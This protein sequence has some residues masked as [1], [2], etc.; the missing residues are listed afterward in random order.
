M[1]VA[2]IISNISG[3]DINQNRQT[4]SIEGDDMTKIT[5]Q[6]ISTKGVD[7]KDVGGM[8]DECINDLNNQGLNNQS[9]S[10][11]N[12]INRPFNAVNVATP[13]RDFADL[14]ALMQVL[15]VSCPWDKKQTNDSLLP[16]ALEEVYELVYAINSD[17][18]ANIK[19]ELGDVLLQVIFHA[20]LYAEQ[21][22][23]DMGDVIYALSDKLIRRHPHIFAS[24]TLACDGEV[25]KRWNEIK[26]QEKK[27]T[28]QKN[29][30]YL[31]NTEIGTALMQALALQQATAKVGFDFAN[32]TD[33]WAKL[34][35][36]LDELSQI[37]PELSSPLDN[38]TSERDGGTN[39][40]KHNTKNPTQPI[41]TIQADLKQRLQDELGD[42]LFALVNVA[43]KLDIDPEI[44][45][46]MACQKYRRRFGFVEQQLVQAGKTLNE[47]TLTE[48][49]LLWQQAKLNE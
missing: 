16:Y 19:E 15:R 28:G 20:C 22:K 34:T 46:L 35:E 6:D 18:D 1:L 8:S 44:A 27:A 11:Q 32:L 47:A 30:A 23:F 10:S 48:M 42:C 31:A 29:Q 39:L 26:A 12:S 38:G 21:G 33:T 3:N 49:D 41:T 17:D 36:E 24:E 25:K 14:L 9:L 5:K 4:K 43:R 40:L 37:V 13:S 45:T 2:N 7:S